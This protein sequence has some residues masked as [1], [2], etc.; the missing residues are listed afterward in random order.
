VE[1]LLVVDLEVAAREVGAVISLRDVATPSLDTSVAE[2]PSPLEEVYR[3]L[4]TGTRDYVRKNRISRR[5][6]RTLGRHRQ[7]T[8]RHRGR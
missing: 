7:F 1:A 6:H 5:R 2:R 3:A 8:G 4:V